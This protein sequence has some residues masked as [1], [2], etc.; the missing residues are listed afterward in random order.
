MIL[1]ETRTRWA[2]GYEMICNMK[3][4]EKQEIERWRMRSVAGYVSL[5][6]DQWMKDE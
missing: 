4:K 3:T 1:N 2:M 6:T 5:S